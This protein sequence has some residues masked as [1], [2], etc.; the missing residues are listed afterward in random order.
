MDLFIHHILD[1]RV[2]AISLAMGMIPILWTT[3]PNG[4]KFDTNDWRVAGGI[5]NGTYSFGT[6]ETILDEA[7][8]LETGSVAPAILFKDAVLT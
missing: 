8:T 6:F 1:D 4:Q 3:A 5:V 7:S 2:R